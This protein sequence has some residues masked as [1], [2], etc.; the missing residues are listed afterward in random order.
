MRKIA[1]IFGLLLISTLSLGHYFFVL[2]ID[3]PQTDVGPVQSVPVSTTTQ[4]FCVQ[5]SGQIDDGPWSTSLSGEAP[6]GT[7]VSSDGLTRFLEEHVTTTSTTI[8]VDKTRYYELRGSTE[9]RVSEADAQ[10]L[11]V[12]GSA[13]GGTP[14]GGGEESGTVNFLDSL[15]YSKPAYVD[16]PTLY[17][18]P[19]SPANEYYV[20]LDSGSG[21]TCSS[22]TPCAFSGLNGKTTSGGT[23]VYMRGTARLNINSITFAGTSGS[24]I[25]VKPWGTDPVVMTAAGGCTA[26]NANLI[27]ATGLQYVVFDGGEDMLFR[28]QGSGCTGN[29]NGYSLVVNGSNKILWRVR[30]DCQDSSGPGLGIATTNDADSIYWINSELYNCDR[31]YGVY[32]GGGSSCP[33]GSNGHDDLIF[34]NSIFRGIDGRGIQV[35][36]R[37]SS[38]GVIVDGNV[39]Y[40]IGYND[41]GSSSIS[42]GVQ[43]ANACGVT[44]GGLV[45]TNNMFWD[46]GGGCVLNF[47]SASSDGEFLMLNNSC[48]DYGNKTPVSLNSHGFTCYSDGCNGTLRNNI[49]VHP[50]NGGINA[51]NRASGW[52]QSNNVTSGSSPAPFISVS[53]SST[54]HMKIESGSSAYEAG[55][56]TTGDVPVD[57]FGS[58]RSVTVDVGAHEASL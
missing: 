10:L 37:A 26:A 6:C 3:S 29:Q 56:N 57:I 11:V 35:E 45:V 38:D 54:D 20:D 47:Q 15:S 39:F 58:T 9:I 17:N 19:D 16:V 40:D 50:A 43:V 23:V 8:Q 4:W 18:L 49:I 52:T 7:R 34:R 48:R 46:M 22:G 12:N 44:T 14:G 42:G 28:F 51:I 30:L 55:F 1:I 5:A 2:P 53:T 32:T 33:G 36:P 21:T 27:T 13:G 24:R 25:W 31:Y 41:S